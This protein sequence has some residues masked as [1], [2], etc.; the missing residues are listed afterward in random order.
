M[1]GQWRRPGFHPFLRTQDLGVLPPDITTTLRAPLDSTSILY[2]R[3]SSF[4]T[5][6]V[7]SAGLL[8]TTLAPVSAPFNQ[9]AWGAPPLAVTQLAEVAPP[10]TLLSKL[11]PPFNQDDWPI[12]SK[13]ARLREADAPV[14]ILPSLPPG[15]LPFGQDDWP[16]IQP[17]AR[18]SVSFESRNLLTPFLP[19]LPF[20]PEDWPLLQRI[21]GRQANDPLNL[22]TT[23]L[24]PVVA[25]AAPFALNIWPI[26]PQVALLKPADATP[27]LLLQLPPGSLPFGQDDWPL[28]QRVFVR[29]VVD[30]LNLLTTLLAPTAAPAPFVQRD[31]ALVPQF[32]TLRPAEPIPDTLLSLPPG[33]LAFSQTSWPIQPRYPVQQRLADAPRNIT[34][35]LPAQQVAAGGIKHKR[36]WRRGSS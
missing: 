35:N 23:T 3:A 28:L 32:V 36:K 20:S 26:Q 16:I 15:S 8:L 6:V 30:P 5:G 14:N 18:V 13:L 12:Q 11:A 34:I 1:P 2:E 25:P 19:P 4:V 33:K 10:N 27:N 29:Q 22:L 17:T 7:V 9:E 24:A 21:L 31:W